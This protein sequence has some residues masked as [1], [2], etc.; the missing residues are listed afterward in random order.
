MQDFFEKLWNDFKVWF[1]DNYGWAHLL[2]FVVVA[3]A[4]IF[5]IKLILRAVDR[6]AKKTKGKKMSRL[7]YSFLSNTLRVVLYFIYFL[8]IFMMLGIDLS[9]VITILSASGLAVSLMLQKVASNFASGMILVA[10]KPFEEGDYVSCNGV[11]GTVVSIA[12]FSTKLLTP[13]NKI[14]VVP[15]STL[16]D[17]SVTNY[18]T[19]PKR[20]VDMTFSVS[21]DS[22][23]DVVKK[24]LYDV[25]DAHELI[26]HEDGY[27]VRLK[28]HG[29]SALVFVCRFWTEKANYWQC[30]FDV[31]EAVFKKLKEVGVEIPYN[32][33]DVNLFKKD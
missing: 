26:L 10:N 2:A 18:S 19:N 11:E 27:T 8:L 12:I 33:L 31:N 32:K 17:N 21:Y 20:R 22:D 3:I 14:V 1:V 9:N 29:S 7:A 24:C 5:V 28:E 4:G 16:A 30:Y 13:D 25:L 15:N 6:A 23:I